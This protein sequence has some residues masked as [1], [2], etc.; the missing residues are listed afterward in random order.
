MK[1]STI[2]IISWGGVGDAL[3]TTPLFRAIK[4]QLPGSRTVVYSGWSAHHEVFLNNPYID[5]LRKPGRLSYAERLLL[6]KFKHVK[7]FRP[8][9]GDVLPGLLYS[10]NATE[11]IAEMFGVTLK[12]KQVMI[13][14]TK[15]EEE[16]GKHVVSQYSTPVAIH[17]TSRGSSNKNWPISHWAELVR[18]NPQYTFLQLGVHT[19]ELVPGVVDLR[20]NLPQLRAQF[21]VLKYARAFVGVD[22]SFSNATNAFG[23]PGVVLYGPSNPLV[24]GHSNNHNLYLGLSCAPCLDI[25]GGGRCPYLAPCMSGIS[26]LEVE[27][28]LEQQLTRSYS[29]ISPGHDNGAIKPS[30]NSCG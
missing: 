30:C 24:W 17:V 20:L 16:I 14:L 12:Y 10:K 18:R 1:H 29:A 23:T 19:E 13:F 2:R 25:L 6:R 15:E 21:A 22:S 3:L 28:A 9:Y 8:T 26:V 7:L 4:E 27:R 5:K 11:I